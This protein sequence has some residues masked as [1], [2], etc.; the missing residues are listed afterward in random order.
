MQRRFPGEEAE[1]MS[2]NETSIQAPN[3]H[4]NQ[5]KEEKIPVDEDNPF[6]K[7]LW[8]TLWLLSLRTNPVVASARL[9]RSSQNLQT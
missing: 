2:K 6:S 5:I 1:R 4:S 3:S 9:H 7:L 8:K